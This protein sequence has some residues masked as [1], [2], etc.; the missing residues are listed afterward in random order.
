MLH[1]WWE[2]WINW[3]FNILTFS[4]DEYSWY[5]LPSTTAT[6]V[7]LFLNLDVGSLLLHTHSRSWNSCVLFPHWPGRV[8]SHS[9]FLLQAHLWFT[10]GKSCNSIFPELWW[11]QYVMNQWEKKMWSTIWS[12]TWRKI[13]P[14]VGCCCSMASPTVLRQKRALA[15]AFPTRTLFRQPLVLTSASIKISE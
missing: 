8:W 3:N 6:A 11:N 2:I 5:A 4:S 13:A 1:I 14:K 9:V 10:T 7:P 15:N 12:R